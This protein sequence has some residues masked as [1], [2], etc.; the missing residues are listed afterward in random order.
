MLEGRR[1]VRALIRKALLLSPSAGSFGMSFLGRDEAGSA[2]RGL[3]ERF[4]EARNLDG[5]ILFR[6]FVS[7]F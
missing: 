7:I 1:L 6:F 5:G 3:E 4:L 2:G